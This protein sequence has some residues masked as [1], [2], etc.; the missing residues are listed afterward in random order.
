MA[1]RK[2][3]NPIGFT[4]WP[5]TFW[6][7]ASLIALFASLV[8]VHNI[9]PPAPSNPIPYPGV[10]LTEAW[11]DLQF[12]TNGYH[13]YNSRRNDQVRDW[14]L[15][16]IEAILKRNAPSKSHFP[17]A[18]NKSSDA[19][20]VIINDIYS[21]L[22]FSSADSALSV[23]FTGTNIIVYIRGTEDAPGLFW[24]E[25]GYATRS[26]ADSKGGVLVNA[27]FDSVPSG[28]GATDDGVGVITILQLISYFTVPQNQPKR[29][30][31]ALL[32][33]GEEDYLN[34]AY[35]FSQHPIS[36]FPH[37]FLNLEGAGAGGRAVLFR[38]TDTQVTKFYKRAPHPFG[39]VVS[40]D[41]FKRGLV[42][43][44]TDYVVFNGDLGMR[45]LDVAFFEPRSRYHTREDSAK[46]TSKN[47]LWH[48]LSAS[49]ATMQGLT[50]DMSSEFD[51]EPSSQGK[52]ASGEGSESVWFDVFGE[53]FAVFDLHSLFAVSVTLLVATPILFLS[54]TLLLVHLDK[55]YPFSNTKIV[56]EVEEVVR[57]DGLHA[58]FRTPVVYVV[59]IGSVVGLAFLLKKINPYII[60]GSPYSVWR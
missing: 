37:T 6:S 51:G 40:A 59:S 55:W 48:M 11:R 44:Q 23:A 57:L 24:T 8:T 12:L 9:V 58:F 33:N 42:R 25:S 60:S 29:G 5:V 15:Q 3:R 28:F 18:A 31:V 7:I 34:G 30:I 45:G 2:S 50:S 22:T 26:K 35:A 56:P 14:L 54:L 16:R 1:K 38:S 36:T 32:N 46:Y 19:P 43:S 47:S 10:N 39:T 49:I 13:P 41:G 17:M 20:A 21:N 52:V 4:P 53:R 27:H